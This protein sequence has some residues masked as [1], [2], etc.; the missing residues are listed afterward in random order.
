MLW[1]TYIVTFFRQLSV[2]R[3]ELKSVQ[4]NFSVFT[5]VRIIAYDKP[6][7][8]YGQGKD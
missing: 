6:W 5:L 7:E 8:I 2:T 4:L 3:D 1:T